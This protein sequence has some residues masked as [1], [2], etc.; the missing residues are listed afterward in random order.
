M[1]IAFEYAVVS[2]AE[3]F[4]DAD[5]CP[6]TTRCSGLSELLLFCLCFLPS[7]SVQLLLII[8][9]DVGF[10]VPPD[11]MFSSFHGGSGRLP[12]LLCFHP[13]QRFCFLPVS[14]YMILFLCW[15][16]LP[17]AQQ[18]QILLRNIQKKPSMT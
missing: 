7:C 3:E 17:L 8:P 6:G 9:L 14:T 4:F 18:C 5:I 10:A 16:L 11:V 1:D 12:L 2:I 15:L 13:L